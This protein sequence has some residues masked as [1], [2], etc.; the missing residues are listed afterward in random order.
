[1]DTK[2]KRKLRQLIQTSV[3]DSINNSLNTF[4][5]ECGINIT[6]TEWFIALLYANEEISHTLSRFDDVTTLV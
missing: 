6:D 4:S 5:E 3:I 2:Q 1:M